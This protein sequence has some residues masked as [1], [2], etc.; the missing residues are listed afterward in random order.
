[1]ADDKIFSRTEYRRVIAWPERIRRE[2]PF[3]ASVFAEAAPRRLLDV[4]CGTGEHTRHFAEEGWEAVGIDISEKMVEDAVELAGTTERGGSARYELRAAA[5]AGG[6]PEV[7]FGGAICIGNT[8]AFLET[9]SELDAV[10]GGV[11]AALVPGARFL[12][13][14]L[15]YEKIVGLSIRNLPVNY[16]PLPDEEGEGEIVFLRIMTPRGDG[17]LDFYP[18]TLTL[19]PGADPPVEVRSAR[20]GKHT[21]WQRQPLEDAF[22]RA[23]FGDL[24]VLGGMSDTPFSALETPDL[25]M[26]ATRR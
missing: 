8:F 5:D 24:R 16:R 17:A 22:G 9:E 13:Q 10:L 15:N 2:A 3:L 12:V 11:A 6:L 20:K 25:V 14:L 21:A 23:G 26:I 7:R 1:V 4:G 19:R 18:I